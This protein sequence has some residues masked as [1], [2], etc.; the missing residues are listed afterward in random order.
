M[1][2]KQLRKLAGGKI[3]A[4]RY[5][6]LNGS[7][8]TM[9]QA[10]FSVLLNETEPVDLRIDANSLGMYERGDQNCP[11]DKYEKIMLLGK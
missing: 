7:G 10:E 1:N 2:R 6:N 9:S 5:R 4:V 11:S 8:R 3:R